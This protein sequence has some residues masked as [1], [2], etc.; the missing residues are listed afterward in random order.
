MSPFPFLMLGATNLKTKFKPHKVLRYDKDERREHNIHTPTRKTKHKIK[1]RSFIEAFKC[2][3][4]VPVFSS[5]RFE[6]RV[7]KKKCFGKGMGGEPASQTYSHFTWLWLNVNLM[8]RIAIISLRFS[9]QNNSPLSHIHT[10]THNK[11][12]SHNCIV[13]V[14]HTSS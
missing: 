1:H 4:C 14:I 8:Y 3:F 11:E 2:L 6:Q 9:S 12:R 13:G 10:H 7:K 5:F